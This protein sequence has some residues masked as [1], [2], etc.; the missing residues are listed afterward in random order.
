MSIENELP[1]TITYNTGGLCTRTDVPE[2]SKNIKRIG[3]KN[4]LKYFIKC[5]NSLSCV[6]GGTS[7]RDA[8]Q[9][10]N[11]G[12]YCVLCTY[13]NTYTDETRISFEVRRNEYEYNSGTCV[14]E[15]SNYQ[16]TP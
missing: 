11:N 14:D 7:I 10:S 8:N 13:G 12:D 2:L 3:N 15:S 4:N 1:S 6:L 16:W 5:G 9:S